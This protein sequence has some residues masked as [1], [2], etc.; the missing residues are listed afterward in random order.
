MKFNQKFLKFFLL[1]LCFITLGYSKFYAQTPGM[2]LGSETEYAFSHQ[3]LSNDDLVNDIIISFGEKLNS[4]IISIAEIEE[5]SWNITN[6]DSLKLQGIGKQ[7]MDVIFEVPGEYNVE[8]N[9]TQKTDTK[10]CQHNNERIAFRLKVLDEK[11]EILFEELTLS[12]SL[13]GNIETKGTILSVPIIYSSYF[14]K[15][16]DLKGFKMTSSGVNTSIIG[17]VMNKDNQLRFGKN[18]I[19]F[20]LSG[21]ATPNSYIMFDF[22]KYNKLIQTYYLPNV[23]K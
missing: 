17:E 1:V 4:T 14:D 22:Y 12:N 19:K 5:Y 20:S 13:I 16:G 3:K 11:Y 8:L 21:K 2:V 6:G 15:L 7:I 10:A 9:H 23:I 18:L